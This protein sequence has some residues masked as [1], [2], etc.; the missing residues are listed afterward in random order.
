M[1]ILRKPSG[2]LAFLSLLCLGLKEKLVQLL[3][4]NYVVYYVNHPYS[5]PFPIQSRI[6]ICSQFLPMLMIL[7]WSVWIILWT[8]SST[9]ATAYHSRLLMMQISPAAYVYLMNY[10]SNTDY[11]ATLHILLFYCMK[12]YNIKGTARA[13]YPV[14]VERAQYGQYCTDIIGHK[15]R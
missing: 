10:V 6:E 15:A 12:P 7:V 2:G 8:M 5:L 9:L 4:Y 13:L 3:N 11:N 1:V 14:H